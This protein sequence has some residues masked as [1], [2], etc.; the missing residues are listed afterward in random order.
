MKAEVKG[1]CPFCG[2]NDFLEIITDNKND[3][4][5]YYVICNYCLCHGGIGFTSNQAVMLWNMRKK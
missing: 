2:S 4:P 5:E 3:L 1:K